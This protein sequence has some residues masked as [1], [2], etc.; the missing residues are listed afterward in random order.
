MGF[1]FLLQICNCA[2]LLNNYIKILH[3]KKFAKSSSKALFKLGNIM[4]RRAI[5]VESTWVVT[6]ANY[7]PPASSNLLLSVSL[8]CWGGIRNVEVEIEV[9]NGV[10]VA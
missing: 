9:G 8:D 4:L 2:F 7:A 1:F 5:L 10:I 3:S 6:E